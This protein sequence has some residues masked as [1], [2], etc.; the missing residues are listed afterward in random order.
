M[1]QTLPDACQLPPYMNASGLTCA[2]AHAQHSTNTHTH[3]SFPPTGG[4][5][6]MCSVC[7]TLRVCA[8]VCQPSTNA[9]TYTQI[10]T[11][12]HK[13]IST[14]MHSAR[15]RKACLQP[16]LCSGH[17]Q[18]QMGKR[19]TLKAPCCTC[20]EAGAPRG[21]DRHIIPILS[22]SKLLQDQNNILER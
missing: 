8:C 6:Y 4:K 20:H 2:W 15:P 11:S 14:E 5:R 7:H 3:P 9:Q 18:G 16:G 13:N 10:H 12:P 1:L 17:A 21:R 19:E 22:T